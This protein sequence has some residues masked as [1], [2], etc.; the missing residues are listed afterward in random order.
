M[1]NYA[2][3]QKYIDRLQIK[4]I[5]KLDQKIDSFKKEITEAIINKMKAEL[6]NGKKEIEK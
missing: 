5:D 2:D 3:F 6:Y 4:L 1:E